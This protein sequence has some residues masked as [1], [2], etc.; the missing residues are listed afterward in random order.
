M[1]PRTSVHSQTYRAILVQLVPCRLFALLQRS[2]KNISRR[3]DRATDEPRQLGKS[4]VKMHSRLWNSGILSG[5]TSFLEI[6]FGFSCYSPFSSPLVLT[7]PGHRCTRVRRQG[8]IP[9]FRIEDVVLGQKF[10]NKIQIS[11]PVATTSAALFFVKILARLR[12]N[13]TLKLSLVGNHAADR[14]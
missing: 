6:S 4:L 12:S 11:D 1:S 9:C 13:T 2:R 10:A 14:Q 8:R 3:A 5:G 7:R